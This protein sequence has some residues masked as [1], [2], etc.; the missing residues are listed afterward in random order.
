MTNKKIEKKIETIDQI[1]DNIWVTGIENH[2]YYAR[3]EG[4]INILKDKLNEV[5][6]YINEKK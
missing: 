6:D 4:K 2:T 3:M 1:A 5:I